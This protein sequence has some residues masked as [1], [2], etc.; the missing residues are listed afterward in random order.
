MEGDKTGTGMGGDVV[1]ILRL[2]GTEDDLLLLLPVPRT[3]VS[4][5]VERIPDRGDLGPLLFIEDDD[6]GPFTDSEVVRKHLVS[7]TRASF[8]S[9]P[10]F[11]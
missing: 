11:K 1:L 2:R 8:V 7:I 5:F 9:L 4:E 3:F 6:D 10:T